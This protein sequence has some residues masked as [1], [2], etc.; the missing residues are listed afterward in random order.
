MYQAYNA[1]DF[2]GEGTIT[3][4]QFMRSRIVQRLKYEHE[5]IKLFLFRESLFKEREPSYKLEYEVFKKAF[6]PHLFHV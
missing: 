5:D 2:N 4:D 6:F 1:I 3:L